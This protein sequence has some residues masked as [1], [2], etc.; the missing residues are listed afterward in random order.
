MDFEWLKHAITGDDTLRHKEHWLTSG[1][2][3]I[4]ILI[5][6]SIS[7]YFLDGK[8]VPIMAASM[9]ASAV[10]LFAVPNSRFSQPWPFIGG[11]LISAFIGVSCAQWIPDQI[12][13]VSTA[14]A[15]ALLFMHYLRCLHP[16]GGAAAVMAVVGGS[17][18]QSLGYSFVL[19]PVALNVIVML[20]LALLINNLILK[21]RY[22]TLSNATKKSPRD[23]PQRT[24]AIKFSDSDLEHA[25]R[26]MNTFID[27]SKEDLNAIYGLARMHHQ[28]TQLGEVLCR[29]VMVKQVMAVEYDSDLDEVWEIMR[30]HKI[31]G[32][33]VIDR[34]R[35]VVGIVTLSD[36]LREADVSSHKTMGEKL[37]SFIKPTPGHYSEKYEVAGQVMT[38]GVL[39]MR[40]ERHIAELI[41]LFVEKDIHH[42]PIVDVKDKLVGMITRTTV[43][44]VLL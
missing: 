2:V 28:K 30:C 1:A 18:L 43:M 31:S 4:T 24:D 25:L 3:L 33:P 7:A 21:Q 29:D 26:D 14:S 15:L 34:A 11:H 37:R 5:V 36:L 17:E 42:I 44:S 35:R 41:P 32:I 9:G 16:P 27:V 13:A 39:T 22:P 19:L 40:E 20:I 38:T 8:D 6:A 10:L 23:A 12:V